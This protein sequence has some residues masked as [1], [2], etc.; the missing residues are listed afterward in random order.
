M[1]NF[2]IH[3]VL[4]LFALAFLPTRANGQFK[5]DA[6]SQTYANPNDTTQRDSIDTMFSFK[7]FFIGEHLF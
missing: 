5:K 6:F 3:I 2:L 7:E 1:R 4:I